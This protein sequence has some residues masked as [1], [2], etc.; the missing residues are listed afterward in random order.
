MNR[1]GEPLTG[2]ELR[3]ANYYNTEFLK[4]VEKNVENPFWKKRLCVVDKARMEDIEFVSELFFFIAEGKEQTAFPKEMD[5][6]YK[7]YT[8]PDALDLKQVQQKFDT[9][10]NFL[11]DLNLDYELYRIGGI[12]HLYGLFA[13]SAYC[14][15]NQIATDDIVAELNSFYVELRDRNFDNENVSQYK[16]SMSARTKSNYQ[17]RKRKEALINFCKI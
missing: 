11:S 12:S 17:R 5:T 4:C 3:N 2:Q 13:F 7:R 16:I 6:L 14:I 9:I 15:K 1:N 8:K 10:T